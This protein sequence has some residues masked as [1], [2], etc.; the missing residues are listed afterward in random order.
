MDM[1]KQLEDQV[2][3][4]LEEAERPMTAE[5]IL[6]HL[7]PVSPTPNDVADVL[8]GL[9]DR[10]AVE[11]DGSY[12]RRATP[13]PLASLFPEPMR[14]DAA[15]VIALMRTLDAKTGEGARYAVL[16]KLAQD[17]GLS[18]DRVLDIVTRLKH[19]GEAYS[20]GGDRLR[21]SKT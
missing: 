11:R 17:R 6:P 4:V 1:R 8:A 19:R 18:A 10:R 15:K 9:S 7:D 21:L 12:F 20:V 13:I 2:A 3:R 16:V 5:E 14:D